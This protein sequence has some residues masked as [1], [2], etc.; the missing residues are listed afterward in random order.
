MML[1]G[2]PGIG[3][4]LGQ[5]AL[6]GKDF[7]KEVM[8]GCSVH[9]IEIDGIEGELCLHEKCLE[10]LTEIKGTGW[11]NLPLGPLREVYEDTATESFSESLSDA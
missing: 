4:S 1:H 5:C 7:M 10:Q 2:M 3:G 11:E 9:T 6:C 8:L